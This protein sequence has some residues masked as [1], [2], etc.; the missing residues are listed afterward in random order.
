MNKSI[1]KY[2][3][4][5]CTGGFCS[6]GRRHYITG[7]LV[8]Y[9]LNRCVSFFFKHWRFGEDRNTQTLWWKHQNL[10]KSTNCLFYSLLTKAVMLQ[11]KL[12]VCTSHIS[13]WSVISVP[14]LVAFLTNFVTN[15]Q[16]CS[17]A[18]LPSLGAVQVVLGSVSCISIKL[19]CPWEYENTNCTCM[20]HCSCLT[21]ADNGLAETDTYI[22]IL[23]NL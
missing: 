17:T 14:I 13:Q 21:A 7:S 8:A 22:F 6:F 4:K 2:I 12:L 11:T 15:T 20:M 23:C 19:L 1:V 9:V 10:K 3:V 16:G 5:C 18:V